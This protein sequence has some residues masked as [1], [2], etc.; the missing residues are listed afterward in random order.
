MS[1]ACN[2]AGRS[3]ALA[4]S[5]VALVRSRDS[6]SLFSFSTKP[7]NCTLPTLLQLTAAAQKVSLECA[8]YINAPWIVSLMGGARRE[9]V[10]IRVPGILD[11]SMWEGACEGTEDCEVSDDFRD[12]FGNVYIS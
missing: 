11:Y 12:L 4:V 8:T 7:A 2:P 10:L 5:H 9:D 3:G 1:I 6:L